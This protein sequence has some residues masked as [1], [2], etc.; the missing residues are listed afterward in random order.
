VTIEEG[1][2]ALSKDP[3]SEPAP[4]LEYV[5]S[6]EDYVAFNLHVAQTHQHYR[7][8]PIEGVGVGV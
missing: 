2:A 4:R 3:V 1:V 7:L 6:N 5:L 8:I